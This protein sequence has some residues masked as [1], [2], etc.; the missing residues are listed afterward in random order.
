[1]SASSAAV[2]GTTYTPLPGR[3]AEA[4]QQSSS[5][6]VDTCYEWSAVAS[7]NPATFGNELRAV[8][9]VG[10]VDVWAVGYYI[11]YSNRSKNETLVEHWNG[12]AWSVVPSPNAA[13]DDN[14]LTGVAAVG[15]NDV[16]AVGY[17][18]DPNSGRNRALIEHWN[19]STWSVVPGANVNADYTALSAVAAVGANDVW[20]V[21]YSSTASAPQ[22]LIEHWNGSS[23]SLVPSPIL[24]TELVS[25][26]AVAAVGHNDVWAVGSYID[27]SASAYQTLIVHWNGSSWSLVPSPNVI[28]NDNELRGIAAVSSSDIWAVGSYRTS[29]TQYS[30]LIE[31]WDGSSWSIVASPNPGSDTNYFNGVT[32]SSGNDV[33]AVGFYRNTSGYAQTLVEHWDGAGWSTVSSPGS[34]NGPSYLYGAAAVSGTDAWAVGM[35]CCPNYTLVARYGVC[36]TPPT[37]TLTPTPE[38]PRCP[39]ERFTDV[40]PTDYFYNAVQALSND[41]ILSGYNTSPPCLNGLW[42]PCFNPYNS[43]TRGQISKVVSLAAGFN[44]PVSGQ[45][46]EDVLPGST[47]YT[48]I[49]RMASRNIISGYLCGGVGEPCGVIQKP[50]FRPGS[51]VTR[52]QLS[53][54]VASAFGWTE[55]VSG[56]QFQDVAPGSTFYDYI[57][58]LANRSII[59][60]YPCGGAGEPCVPGGNL[61]YFRPSSNVV[62]GQ[63]AKIVQLARTQPTSTPTSTVIPTATETATATATA[64]DIPATYTAT[65]AVTTT[66][67]PVSTAT[68]MIRH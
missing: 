68:A 35:S 52:G 9:P 28:P 22:M 24:N 55:P 47:F 30:T 33:W 5:S 32:A 43:S 2:A 19:G 61:P 65:P 20:A 54:M 49:E 51:S 10:A 31:H 38:P 39:G 17:Y 45:T 48:Y 14:F 59:N 18:D 1:M 16:W 44:D 66:P 21:G 36:V 12:S 46:F 42:I 37:P 29:Q 11:N 41:S 50:Y 6:A 63:T 8:A 27:A 58:R 57:A 64:T 34:A 67:T 53:K 25:L 62:R 15:A 23:W 3:Q 40:C 60:G 26:A 56:Q 4:A 13:V 7:P